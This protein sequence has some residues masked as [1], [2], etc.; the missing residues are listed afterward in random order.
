LGVTAGS[1]AAAPAAFD[2]R[3]NGTGVGEIAFAAVLTVPAAVDLAPGDILAVVAPDPADA[4]LAD[5]SISLVL[6]LL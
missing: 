5:L 2:L 1:A 6:A 3:H 4:G